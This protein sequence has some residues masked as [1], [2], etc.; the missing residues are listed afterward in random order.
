MLSQLAKL[1]TKHKLEQFRKTT[2][3]RL[4]DTYWPNKT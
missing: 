1:A 2:L 3:F 4:Q